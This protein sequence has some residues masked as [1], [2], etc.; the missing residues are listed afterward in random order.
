MKKNLFHLFMLMAFVAMPLTSCEKDKDPQEEQSQHNPA[1]DEDQVEIQGYDALDWL[2]NSIAVVD[3]KGEIIR[4]VYGK[5]LD[6]SN[7]NVIS[8]PVNNIE[9]AEN[10]FLSWVAPGKEATKVDGGYDYTLTSEGGVVQGG[11]TFRAA[12]GGGIAGGGGSEGGVIAR[13]EVNGG[14]DLKQVSQVNFISSD[15]WPENDATPKYE[16]G[17]LYIL[18][19]DY[20]VRRYYDF[21]M[22]FN[23]EKGDVTFYCLIGNDNGQEALLIHL[24]PDENN[25]DTH[26]EVWEYKKY[27]NYQYLASVPEAEKVLKYHDEHYEEWKAMIK[28]MESIGHV[29]DWHYGIRTTGNAEFILNSYNNTKDRLKCLDLDKHPGKIAEIVIDI[30]QYRYILVRTFPPYIEN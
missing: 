9:M 10:I 13:M 26:G 2:Q 20:L 22:P 29:W 7:P 25:I 21:E 30:F 17:K 24:S 11:V 18:N 3:S 23:V 8:V 4:R 15:L 16:A 5:P 12:G 14:T 1:S 28:Y 6:A 27:D 19:T